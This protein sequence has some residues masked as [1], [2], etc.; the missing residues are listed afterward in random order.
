MVKWRKKNDRNQI[1]EKEDE[2]CI[3]MRL[4]L[5]PGNLDDEIAAI[6]YENRGNLL[7]M[8]SITHLTSENF[9]A[10]VA[11]G[12]PTVVL[13]YLKCKTQSPHWVTLLYYPSW[14]CAVPLFFNSSHCH[15]PKNHWPTEQGEASG[16]EFK[17]TIN[18]DGIKCSLCFHH[19]GMLFQ[20]L[21]SAHSLK[22]Q[23]DLQVIRRA[24]YELC[25]CP[26]EKNEF[27]H[28]WSRRYSFSFYFVIHYNYL[29]ISLSFV[30]QWGDCVISIFMTKHW[31]SLLLINLFRVRGRRCSDEYG[32]LWRVDR[33]LCRR[34]RQL[35]P[36]SFP[37]NHNLPQRPAAPP[38]GVSP[39]LQRNAG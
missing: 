31:F 12:S 2:I 15:W 32:R 16:Y 36:D 14:K 34:A 39:A 7:D 10:V 23:R 33:L 17:V 6:V 22:L 35:P 18:V 5:P 4:C 20:W 25:P 8:D 11:Q 26:C 38:P 21:F 1:V 27:C 30:R 28:L 3:F 37:A 9:H 29:V 19:Q 24:Q 13:F